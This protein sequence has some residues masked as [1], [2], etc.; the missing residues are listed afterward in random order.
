VTL[1]DAGRRLLEHGHAI[2]QRVAMAKEDLG[3]QRD[4]PVGASPWACRR[5]W[6]GA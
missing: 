4:E 2:M 1:T 5:A 3:S 6:R